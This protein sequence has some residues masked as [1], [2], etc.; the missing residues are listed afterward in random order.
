M[1]KLVKSRGTYVIE[2]D[3]SELL[4]CASY[5]DEVENEYASDIMGFYMG[6]IMRSVY[7]RPLRLR[8]G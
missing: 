6:Y 3:I 4:K 2:G 1:E 7:P 5:S 8:N